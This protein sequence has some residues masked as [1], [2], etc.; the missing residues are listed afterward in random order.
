M[1]T[2]YIPLC[3]ILNI[4]HKINNQMSTYTLTLNRIGF[5]REVFM[6]K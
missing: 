6:T 2:S 3:Y 5:V 1:I 4:V